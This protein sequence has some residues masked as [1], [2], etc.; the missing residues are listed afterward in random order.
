MTLCI[1]NSSSN[2]RRRNYTHVIS[3]AGGR[4][5]NPLPLHP[6]C[7]YTLQIFYTFVFHNNVTAKGRSHF[8]ISN[9]TP[10]LK[11][12]YARGILV[13]YKVTSKLFSISTTTNNSRRYNLQALCYLRT[14]E[15][16]KYKRVNITSLIPLKNYIKR[17]DKML[18]RVY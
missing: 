7:F 2:G 15:S 10:K 5:S 14:N 16:I 3:V 18:V 17:F 11:P 1:L 6:K 4:A 8:I 9:Q 12:G 13:F